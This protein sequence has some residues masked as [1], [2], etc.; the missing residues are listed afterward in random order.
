MVLEQTTPSDP[1]FQRYGTIE[2]VES[3]LPHQEP[4][5]G[6]A[7]VIRDIIVGLADGLTVP[8]ALGT[9]INCL[10]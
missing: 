10:I 2:S 5:F 4:H 8:F 1:R 9:Y 3:A 7:F 6:N